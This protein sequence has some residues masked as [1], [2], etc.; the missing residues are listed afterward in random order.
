MQSTTFR[1]NVKMLLMRSVTDNTERLVLY[2]VIAVLLGTIAILLFIIIY[3]MCC[4]PRSKHHHR[5]FR[6]SSTT[7]SSKKFSSR[8]ILSSTSTQTTPEHTSL[9]S[10]DSP[11]HGWIRSPTPGA[12]WVRSLD[13]PSPCLDDPSASPSTLRSLP[14]RVQSGPSTVGGEPVWTT[15]ERQRSQSPSAGLYTNPYRH[16]VFRTIDSRKSPRK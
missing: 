6:L 15:M 4:R 5:I 10:P 16:D 14:L 13:G 12:G 8:N 3:L 11:D 9:L 1:E 2:S 7:T